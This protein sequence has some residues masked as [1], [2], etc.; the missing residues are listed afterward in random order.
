MTKRVV[1][2]TGGIASGKSTVGKMLTELGVLVIDADQLS[3]EVV[4]P[5][6]K[7]LQ[8]VVDVFGTEY[9]TPDGTLDRPKL[10]LMVFSDP[11]ALSCLESIVHPLVA[12]LFS[13]KCAKA[14]EYPTPY[15]VYENAILVETG[16]DKTMDKVIVVAAEPE[17]QITRVMK[18]NKLTREQAEARI[19]AQFS[20][21][22][23]L[24]AADIVIINDNDREA[25]RGRVLEAH[26]LLLS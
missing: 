20:L 5:G 17:L 23:K 25:L 26:Q 1:G 4:E 15:I 8:S 11:T 22:V 3:R 7:G 13:Q 14:Q 9:L 10:G 24:D 21:Q 12:D 2:L 18:R 6:T 19:S 16:L